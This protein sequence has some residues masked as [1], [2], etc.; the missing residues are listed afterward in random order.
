ML[1]HDRHG[2]INLMAYP[3][4]KKDL[5]GV[6]SRW[7]FIRSLIEKDMDRYDEALISMSERVSNYKRKLIER[8]AQKLEIEWGS[9]DTLEN[10][11]WAIHDKNPDHAVYLTRRIREMEAEL[12]FFYNHKQM[13]VTLINNLLEYQYDFYQHYATDQMQIVRELHIAR[14]DGQ[15]WR[16]CALQAYKSDTFMTRFALDLINRQKS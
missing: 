11:L 7:D 8:E 14:R 13:I 15:F 9:R 1:T 3:S 12:N 6:A 2:I 10:V 4:G 5:F 16:E